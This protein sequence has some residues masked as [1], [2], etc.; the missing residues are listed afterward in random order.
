MGVWEAYFLPQRGRSQCPAW[1]QALPCTLARLRDGVAMVQSADLGDANCPDGEQQ[2]PG[3]GGRVFGRPRCGWGDK[4]SLGPGRRAVK[5]RN[6][7][8]AEEPQAP[9]G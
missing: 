9:S 6:E 7:P 2:L 5:P 8:L 4:N 3:P 1:R